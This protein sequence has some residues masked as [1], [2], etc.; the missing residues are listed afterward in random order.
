[1]FVNYSQSLHAEQW[2]EGLGTFMWALVRVGRDECEE[3]GEPKTSV[4]AWGK[5]GFADGP[6]LL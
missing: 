2:F 6:D 5:P 4:P 3:G 1:M